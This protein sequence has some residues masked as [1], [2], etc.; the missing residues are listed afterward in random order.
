MARDARAC[1]HCRTRPALPGQRRC[2]ACAELHRQQEQA[3][4]LE[5]RACGLCPVCGARAAKGRIH[6]AACLNYF[7]ARARST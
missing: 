3:R 5:R 6:C 7:A 1:K 4:R 2:A